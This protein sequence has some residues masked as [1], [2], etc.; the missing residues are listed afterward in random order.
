M[1]KKVGSVKVG[2][3]QIEVIVRDAESVGSRDAGLANLRLNKIWV[4]ARQNKSQREAT[5][6]HEIIEA[7]NYHYELGLEHHKICTLETSIYQVL[8]DN[9]QYFKYKL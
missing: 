7:I 1:N 2:G 3:H 8:K 5:L 9:P 6:I 4:D